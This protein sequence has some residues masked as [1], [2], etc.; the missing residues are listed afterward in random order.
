MTEEPRGR[1]RRDVVWNLVPVAL[2]AVVGLGLKV[3]I[4]KWWDEAALG[5]FNLV[6]FVMMSI[7]I[8]GAGGLQY[9]VLR[10]V[11]EA[12]GDR[13]R[14]AAVVVGALVP[15]VVLAA[16]AT[17]LFIAL[18]HPIGELLQSPAVAEGILWA[19]PALF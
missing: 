4:A 19:A 10:A 8:L 14:V 12:P 5:A 16:L 11:A 9:A 3:L 6:T 1:L 17:A 18:R 7:A 2:L 15:N 13:D